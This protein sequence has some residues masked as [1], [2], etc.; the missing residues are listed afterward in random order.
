MITTW[1]GVGFWTP[2]TMFKFK[3]TILTCTDRE[4]QLGFRQT[5][6]GIQFS[7]LEF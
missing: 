1:E 5:I 3:C 6:F 4:Q 2:Y 7:E